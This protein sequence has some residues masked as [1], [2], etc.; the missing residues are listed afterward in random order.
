MCKSWPGPFAPR[1]RTL[2]RG[3]FYTGVPSA[4]DNAFWHG[5]WAN[6]LAIMGRRGIIVYN[7]PLVY[8]NKTIQIPGIGNHT[9]R[10]GQENGIDVRLALDA[11]DAAHR[12]RLDVALI[13]SQDQNLVSWHPHPRGR[14]F[15]EPLDQDCQRFPG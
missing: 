15:P 2:D 7:R 8:R 11:L 5:S 13:F 9:F 10:S 14:Q 12:N 3:Q 6:K 1:G 4:A